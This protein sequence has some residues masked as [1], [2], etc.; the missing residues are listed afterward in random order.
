MAEILF[1][2]DNWMP[3]VVTD[4][5][6]LLLEVVGGADALHGPRLF[7]APLR[8]EHVAAL[9]ESLRRHLL[10][11]AALLPLCDAAG[12]RG[13]WD[14]EAATALLDPIL[15]GSPEK[16]DATLREVRVDRRVLVAH[17]AGL[18]LLKRRRY[19]EAA[20]SAVPTAD[21]GRVRKHLGP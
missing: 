5:D 12:V 6:R 17:H 18:D 8:E 3:S 16:V 19:F 14:E 4:G 1:S 20:Q 21:W 2:R 11:H 10:L 13:P 15:L 7:T 9:R